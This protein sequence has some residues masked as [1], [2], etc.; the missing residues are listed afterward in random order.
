MGTDDNHLARWR[1]GSKGG[2]KIYWIAGWRIIG[3]AAEAF[4]M[5]CKVCALLMLSPIAMMVAS[6]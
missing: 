3:F 5:R 4:K 6:G 2:Q 1:T